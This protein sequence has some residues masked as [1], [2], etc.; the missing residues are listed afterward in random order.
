[1]TT[2]PSVIDTMIFDRDQSDLLNGT[3]KAYH[4]VADMQR[5]MDACKYIQG[6][7]VEVGIAIP[8]WEKNTWDVFDYSPGT[9]KGLLDNVRVLRGLVRLPE[10]TPDVPSGFDRPTI[11]MA[12]DIERILYDVNE[13]IWSQIEEG[14]ELFFDGTYFFDGEVYFK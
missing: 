6:V 4:N 2:P 1:M 3:K 12:N 10:T 7:L 13:S 11:Q 8:I 9:W 5:I 14:E